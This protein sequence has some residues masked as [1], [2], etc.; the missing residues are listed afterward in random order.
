[1]KDYACGFKQKIVKI[2]SGCQTA[3]QAHR[4]IGERDCMSYRPSSDLEGE[5]TEWKCTNCSFATDNLGNERLGYCVT[6]MIRVIAVNE[7][8]AD[9]FKNYP[10]W[11]E[12][13]IFLCKTLARIE[14][15]EEGEING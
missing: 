7:L 9:L 6:G 12:L 11:P 1:M 5:I 8:R 2:L 14:L 4:I 15:L 3:K 10:S 13:F